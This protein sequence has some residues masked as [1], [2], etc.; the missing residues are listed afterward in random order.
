MPPRPTSSPLGYSMPR[1][2]LPPQCQNELNGLMAAAF[3]PSAAP[4]VR[5]QSLGP[6]SVSGSAQVEVQNP[7]KA[8]DLYSKEQ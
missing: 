3:A 1:G 5:A 4:T 2:A 7:G 6:V 8:C